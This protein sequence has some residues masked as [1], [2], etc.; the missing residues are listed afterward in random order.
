M[1]GELISLG[2]GA[3]GV[4]ATILVTW[5]VFKTKF[6]ILEA[7]VAKLDESLEKSRQAQGA[8]VGKLERWRSFLEGSMRTKSRGLPIMRDEESGE[9]SSAT[10]P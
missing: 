3:L 5:G 6:A 7:R 8:R 9:D 10:K 2:V 4:F 1:L